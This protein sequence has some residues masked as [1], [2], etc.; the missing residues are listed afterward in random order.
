MKL[1]VEEREK[2]IDEL[3]TESQRN[4]SGQ[5]RR[6]TSMQYNGKIL[7]LEHGLYAKTM[8][9]E[10]SNS[11]RKED[12]YLVNELRQEIRELKEERELLLC[13]NTPEME[14]L[15]PLHNDND[16]EPLKSIVGDTVSNDVD[17]VAISIDDDRAVA[18]SGASTAQSDCNAT[19][20]S[21]VEVN[22]DNLHPTKRTRIRSSDK[23]VR[24]LTILLQK[25]MKGPSGQLLLDLEEQR[26]EIKYIKKQNKHLRSHL[27][28][29]RETHNQ[30]TTVTK[31][32][33]LANHY[34]LQIKKWKGKYLEAMRRQHHYHAE[35]KQELNLEVAGQGGFI[36]PIPNNNTNNQKYKNDISLKHC[37]EQ[38]SRLSAYT[39]PNMFIM[40]G[41]N[42]RQQS[43]VPF[44]DGIERAKPV[45]PPSRKWF[46]PSPRKKTPKVTAFKKR[47]ARTTAIVARGESLGSPSPTLA[48]SG[49][50]AGSTMSPS[51]TSIPRPRTTESIDNRILLVTDEQLAIR[52][53]TSG[54]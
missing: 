51:P 2:K 32:I 46:A 3:R 45:A 29:I 37:S 44:G 26:K 19:P 5:N 9:L 6:R 7:E 10:E 40:E 12:Q 33:Q 50:A 28:R 11:M 17:Q 35:A 16:N 39:P 18:N 15:S 43:Y 4:I 38:T 25:Q 49:W 23:E 1:K 54:S 31:E 34:E 47:R 8:A 41:N 53:T 48:F 13:R 52:P 14:Q 42:Y 20:T 24:R 27:R 22:N 21:F 30:E 36:T